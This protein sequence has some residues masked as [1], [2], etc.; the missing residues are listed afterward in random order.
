MF[1]KQWLVVS[2]WWLV[3]LAN[4][5]EFHLS[6]QQQAVFKEAQQFTQSLKSEPNPMSCPLS[7]NP[8]ISNTLH[9]SPTTNHQTLVFVSFSMGDT[10][11]KQYALEAKKVGA[12]L[13]FRG[14][15]GNS[16]KTTALRLQNLVQETQ[17]S[18]LVDPT[19][20]RRFGIEKVPAVVVVSPLRESRATS[21]EPRFDVVYGLTTLGYAL[22]KMA[23]EGEASRNAETALKQL[24]S[25][26]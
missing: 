1:F 16:I 19:A 23:H 12:S 25:P 24:R 7:T 14:L 10:A 13:V 22:E 17:A 11:L 20:F 5:E 4:A 26:S 9:Q 18:F 2:G 15:I 3:I 8:Q 21:T 6:P